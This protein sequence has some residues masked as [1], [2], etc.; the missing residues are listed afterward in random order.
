MKYELEEITFDNVEEAYKIDRSDVPEAFVDGVP[1]LIEN[2]EFGRDH[3]CI[4][5]AF[6]IKVEDRPVGT[7]LLG[8]GIVWDTDPEDVKD[9]DFYRL[10]FFVLDKN[11]RSQ[12]LGAEVLE[13]TI[14]RV[15][16]D[17]GVAP[18]LLGVHKDNADAARFYERHGF[19]KT[20]Y[21]E[22]NDCYYLREV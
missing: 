6:F 20:N 12:G 9:R 18:I 3:G 21:M 1:N 22:N 4:G 10:V 11:F 5:H 14:R 7:I 2:L 16:N 19:V 15:Y 13:E 17:F 8:E